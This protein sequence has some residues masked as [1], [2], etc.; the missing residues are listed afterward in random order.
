MKSIWWVIIIVL[1]I[2]LAWWYTL[3]RNRPSQPDAIIPYVSPKNSPS[4]TIKGTSTVRQNG[5][6]KT[7]DLR[8]M[9]NF[10]GSGVVSKNYINDEYTFVINANMPD[11]SNGKYYEG[12]LLKKETPTKPLSIGRM[13]KIGQLYVLVFRS[14]H[15]YKEYP[16]VAVT[17]SD[18]NQKGTNPLMAG[19]F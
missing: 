14:Q 18:Q 13:E 3:V 8:P 16:I 5:N 6:E 10:N 19:A 9:N 15:D 7:I 4:P 17:E 12:W 1:I 11:L 2:V